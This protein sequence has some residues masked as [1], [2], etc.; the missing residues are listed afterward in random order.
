MRYAVVMAGGAGTRLWPAATRAVPKQFQQLI[1]RAPL[2][3]ETI[4]RLAT[5]YDRAHILVVTG[6]RYADAIRAAVPD[7][8]SENIIVEP[9][10]RNT[11]AAIALA[12]FAI[13]QRDPDGIFGVFPSD[14]VMLKPEALFAAL[15][16]AVH[17]AMEHRVVDIGVPPNH[18]ETG[19]GYI[20]LGDPIGER[21]GQTAYRVERFVEKPNLARAQ[22]YLAAGNYI[23]NS[24]MFV[25]RA[26]QYLEALR[27]HLPRTH[28]LL[29]A[30]TAAGGQARLVAA[31]EQI[32]N[33]SV[34]YAIME[35]ESDVVALSVDFGWRDVG[36]WAALYDL[37]QKDG[38]GNAGQGRHVT[39]D[40]EGMLVLAGKKVVATV[41]L[42]DL[43]VVETDDVI[44][45]LPRDRA[46]DVK[47]LQ[48]QLE[49]D[50]LQDLL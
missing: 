10:G 34:D 33:I 27:E 45:I 35:R 19:Y 3:V 21:D 9:F 4:D 5:V 42:R 46:Q 47:A 32:E 23:W 37:M 7:L 15:S 2:I 24:G 49:Q 41:G 20:E 36:D 43:V 29:A 6:E 11:A 30:A 14:H 44:L 18:P 38:A 8:S 31:Y 22:S 17:L 1:F 25:W 12:A 40:S 16:Y 26:S 39:V 28:E 48:T 50:G 13:A